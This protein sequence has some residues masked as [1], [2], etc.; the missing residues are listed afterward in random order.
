MLFAALLG[1]GSSIVCCA[2]LGAEYKEWS[3]HPRYLTVSTGAA[4]LDYLGGGGTVVSFMGTECLVRLARMLAER[5]GGRSRAATAMAMR[6]QDIGMARR[7]LVGYGTLRD[8]CLGAPGPRRLVFGATI[9]DWL[10]RPAVAAADLANQIAC[11]SFLY[12][13]TSGAGGAALAAVGGGLLLEKGWLVSGRIPRYREIL[14]L[15]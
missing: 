1:P 14:H 9:A 7:A 6:G 15:L 13:C 2:T 10:V 5:D 3:D 12:D 11:V 8:L 4:L